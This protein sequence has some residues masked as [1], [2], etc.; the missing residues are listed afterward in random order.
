M[1]TLL[2]A[3]TFAGVRQPLYLSNGGDIVANTVFLQGQALNAPTPNILTLNGQ[4]IANNIGLSTIMDWSYY[5]AFSTI[6][7]NNNDMTN[8]N[9][10]TARELS[11]T[12]L[13]PRP[14]PGI[15][16]DEVLVGANLFFA[17]TSGIK[18]AEEVDTYQLKTNG[19]QAQPGFGF[20]T[21]NSPIT[22]N[23]NSI[24]SANVLNATELQVARINAP[25]PNANLQ[26]N[27][28]VD[29]T[30]HDASLGTLQAIQVISNNV[31]SGEIETNVIIL[32]GANN[33]GIIALRTNAQRE[34]LVNGRSVVN[35]G[36]TIVIPGNLSQVI[37]K[38][39][40]TVFGII[41]L[42]YLSPNG[43]GPDGPQSFRSVDYG[44][45]TVTVN[46]NR[47]AIG[48]DRINWSV[49]KYSL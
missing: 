6:N 3:N 9:K 21:F 29:F 20:V 23:G 32:R 7:G 33:P 12:T 28:D 19:I 38:P 10:I 5:P 27:S 49:I 43:N 35:G 22:M 39:G 11:V 18:N 30:G 42:T 24:T 48:G 13:A 2:P 26:I 46:L 40:M 4:P 44:N 45:N 34:L 41:Q 47:V 36:T 17:G 14:E 8:F 25:P 31:T 1:G 37:P 16:A 15:P